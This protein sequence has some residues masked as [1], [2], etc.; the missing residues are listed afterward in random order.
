MQNTRMT[1][2]EKLLLHPSNEGTGAID[3]S[4]NESKDNES[5]NNSAATSSSGDKSSVEGLQRDNQ[6]VSLHET[7]CFK[8]DSLR[9]LYVYHVHILSHVFF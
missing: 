6:V 1:E 4:S 9:V 7:N 3:A 2:L 8:L 5:A